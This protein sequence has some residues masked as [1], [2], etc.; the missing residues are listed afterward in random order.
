MTDMDFNWFLLHKGMQHYFVDSETVTS[1]I[2]FGS[3][4]KRENQSKCDQK[5][6]FMKIEYCLWVVSLPSN[7]M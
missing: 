5:K 3:V 1:R 7:C 6:K 2:H 4:S